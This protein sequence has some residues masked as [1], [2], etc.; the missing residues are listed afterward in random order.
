[1][2]N[3]RY[4]ESCKNN[5]IARNEIT[6]RQCDRQPPVIERIARRGRYSVICRLCQHENDFYARMSVCKSC[7]K[8]RVLLRYNQNRT[9]ELARMRNYAR[10]N[11][12]K[13][14]K[15]EQKYYTKNKPYWQHKKLKRKGLTR[16]IIKAQEWFMVQLF[17]G[18]RCLCC[19]CQE[20]LTIDHIVPISM[21][22]RNIIDNIQPLCKPC[23]SSKGAQVIDYRI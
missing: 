8:E 23:N 13:L 7:H 4:T 22:G 5:S 1:M 17:Y 20:K 15:A 12:D 21:G 9:N 14:R 11:K 6:T 19:G 3:A 16:G 10:N 2:N 18:F